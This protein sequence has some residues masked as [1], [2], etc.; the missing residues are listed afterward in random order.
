MAN[1]KLTEKA[2]ST[3]RSEDM[4]LLIVQTEDVSGV[5]MPVVRRIDPTNAG[6]EQTNKKVSSVFNAPNGSYPTAAAVIEAI[7]RFSSPKYGVS[8]VGGNSQSLTR[9][10][11]A[12]GMTATAGTQEV[13]CRSD[14]DGLKPFERKKCVGTWSMEGGKAKFTVNAYEGD[15]DYA[16]DGTMGDYVAVDVTPFYFIDDR[17]NGILGVSE[18]FHNG[19]QLHPIC[20]NADGTPREHTYIPVYELAIDDNGHA[21]SLPGFH[22]V[23]GSYKTVWDYART[24]GTGDL[25]NLC[26]LEPSVVNHY[27]WLLMTI[28]FATDM[29]TVMPGATAMA[30]DNSHKVSRAGTNVNSVVTTAAIGNAFVA[31]QTIYLG[32]DR[33]TTP[34]GTNAYNVITAIENCDS[35]GTPNPSGTYRL[36]SFDG[37]ARTVSTSTVIASRP[38]ITGSAG[39]V[40]GH[41]GSPVANSAKH[42]F[43]YR[44][45][46][47]VYGNINKTCLDLMDVRVADGDS[48]KLQWYYNNKFLHEGS[49]NTINPSSVADLSAAAGWNLLSVETPKA[50]YKDGY[51]K[52]ESYDERFPGVAVPTNTVGGSA[53]TYYCDY[54]HL[55]LSYLVR[56]VRRCGYLSFGA[57]YGP[58]Y[59]NAYYAPSISLW[60][61][62]GGLY[63]AQ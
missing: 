11:D 18:Y 51:I 49:V 44:W 15:A 27:E 52:E 17:E 63:F 7:E 41:T 14:F 61:Y 24:Y 39:S 10:W 12:V 13:H 56:A 2:V 55:V 1:V 35:D 30:Y 47:N 26:I 45:R 20:K 5:E 53:T 22:P 46:E 48:Y 4:K 50:S 6:M 8:G 34:S 32:S 28:E 31:G 37:P 60:H 57:Y 25:A 38:W 40:L 23:F 33:S 42:P 3:E 62:G 59:V 54:A 9:L 58:R 36:I 21:V 29:Q 43:R 16:E 19:F